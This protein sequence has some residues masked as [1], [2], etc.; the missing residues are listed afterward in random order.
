M[1]ITEITEA[2]NDDLPSNAQPY[3]SKNQGGL[4]TLSPYSNDWNPPNQFK[5]VEEILPT[6]DKKYEAG[7]YRTEMVPTNE[8]LA[9]Q[10]WLDD[11]GGGDPVFEE[12]TDYPVVVHM[13]DGYYHIIDGHH[14][15][16]KAAARKMR[17]IKAYVFTL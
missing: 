11:I 6:L 4:L 2:T 13:K 5:E 12:L 14:R 17:K 7:D 8:L 16:T 15:S 10:Y 1:R 3:K 9:T